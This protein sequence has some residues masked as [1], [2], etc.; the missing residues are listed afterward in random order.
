VSLILSI[1]A[2]GLLII[3]HEAGHMVVARWCGMRVERFSI[4]FPPVIA[5]IPWGGVVYQI[6]AVPLGGFVQ[7][8]GMNPHEQLPADDAGSFENKSLPRRMATIFAG[9]GTNYLVAFLLGVLLFAWFG[10]PASPPLAVIERVAP[11]SAAAAAGLRPTDRVVAV[12]GKPAKWATDVREVV[13]A[14][15][16]RAVVLRVSRDG[17][18]IDVPIQPR[19]DSGEYRIGVEFSSSSDWRPLP[20][21]EAIV[22]AG[23]TP[24]DVSAA[25]LGNLWGMIRGHVSTD[26]VGGPVEIVKQLKGSFDKG[27][28]TALNGLIMLNVIVGLMNLLPLPALDGGRLAFLAYNV[29]TRRRVSVRLETAV[30]TVGILLL[31]G[32]LLMITFRDVRRIFGG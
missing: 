12:D 6:G 4:G 27:V 13:L 10:V 19:L 32:L 28:R 14:S 18:T 24:V 31:F 17:R 21:G 3:V 9:P 22:Q 7:I 25:M 8:A 30:H 16:G 23:R 29:V 15:H 26:S 5:Q 20:L 2:L 1:L 11:R